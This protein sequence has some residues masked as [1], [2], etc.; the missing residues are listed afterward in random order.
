MKRVCWQ[1]FRGDVE[2]KLAHVSLFDDIDTKTN[3]LIETINNALDEQAPKQEQKLR[4]DPCWWRPELANR[5]A[6]IR[7]LSKRIM[8]NEEQ[9]RTLENLKREYQDE[10]KRAKKESWKKFCS[11][12]DTLTDLSRMVKSLQ[13]T[14]ETTSLIKDGGEPYQI[15]PSNHI[16]TYSHTTSPSTGRRR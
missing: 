15:P 3:R 8:R 11:N 10:I 6:K 14:D 9:S 4:R 7:R 2:R 16:R 13:K 5:R 12:T 1:K